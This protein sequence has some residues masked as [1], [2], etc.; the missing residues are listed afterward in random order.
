ME[1][2]LLESIYHGD[3][4]RCFDDCPPCL[5]ITRYITTSTFGYQHLRNHSARKFFKEST[6]SVEKTSQTSR[7]YRLIDFHINKNSFQMCH[8]Y[9]NVYTCTPRHTTYALGK[10]CQQANFKQKPCTN[11]VIWQT[12]YV[13][14]DCDE[15]AIPAWRIPAIT[16]NKDNVEDAINGVDNGQPSEGKSGKSSE[17]R[18]DKNKALSERIV[19][20]GKKVRR[21][22]CIWWV[23]DG[24]V[25][26]ALQDWSKHACLMKHGS[27]SGNWLDI[28][29]LR[30][31]T[32]SSDI[33]A[34]SEL[35]KQRKLQHRIHQQQVSLHRTLQFQSCPFGFVQNNQC[36]ALFT[37]TIKLINKLINAI[38]N[39]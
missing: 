30:E 13:G 23:W 10:Y 38:G 15:C 1:L 25:E 11:R 28:V 16:N 8:F 37:P 35:N 4:P 31:S 39:D 17:Q 33:V 19:G 26:S 3:L 7:L 12:V 9:A 29:T 32:I 20:T 18:K 27:L 22:W 34:I 5:T 24:R 2:V 21:R 14:E 6:Y 36:H